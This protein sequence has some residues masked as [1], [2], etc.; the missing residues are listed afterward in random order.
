MPFKT[1]AVVGAAGSLG[2]PIVQALLAAGFKVTAVARESS[3]STYPEGVEVRKADLRSVESLTKAFAGQDVVIMTPPNTESGNQILFVDAAVAAG[4]KR[5]LPAEWGH[6]TRPGKL[7]GPMADMLSDKTKT[8]D[9][10]IEQAK[11]HPNFTWT[12]IAT[13]MFLDW[14]L[15]NYN[16]FGINFPAKTAMI[17]DSGNALTP[18]S[19]LPFVAQSVVA[20]LQREGQTANRYIDVVEH[21]VSQ[22]QLVRLIEEEAAVKLAVTHTTSKEVARIRDEKMAKGDWTA[23]IE[24]LQV[25]GLSDGVD[26]W[27]KEEEIANAEL[28]LQA[29]DIREIIREF[30][31]SQSA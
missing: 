8:V 1:V 9:Y 27:V 15:A 31:K 23:F 25:F 29:R 20:V 13:R 16:I 14:C 28:G 4:V 18:T 7:S 6:N 22:N 21:H 30:V 17:I 10:L 12:G 3:T 26:R 11:Q 2:R 19:S 5:F 24:E